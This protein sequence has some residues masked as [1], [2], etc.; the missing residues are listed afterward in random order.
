[1]GEIVS[2]EA[3]RRARNC[4]PGNA[5]ARVEDALVERLEHAV[6]RLEAA[7]EEVMDAGEVDEPVLRRELLAVSGA[8]AGGRYA[9]AADRTERLIARLRHN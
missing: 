9:L 2:I 3:Y 5:T 4:R 8:V 1:M 6:R 7:L